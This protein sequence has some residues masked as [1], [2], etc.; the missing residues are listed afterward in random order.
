VVAIQET[1]FDD[2]ANRIKSRRA[3]YLHTNGMH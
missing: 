3:A 1:A 2:I